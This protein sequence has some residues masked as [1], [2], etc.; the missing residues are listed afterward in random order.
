MKVVITGGCGFIGTN[1]AW[2]LSDKGYTVK[3]IDNFLVGKPTGLPPVTLCPRDINDIDDCMDFTRNADVVVHLAAISGVEASKMQP[4]LCFKT[5]VIGT[6]N[7]LE[8]SAENGVMK[9]IIA[10]SGAADD[11][12]SSPYAMSKWTAEYISQLICQESC[13]LR[14]AN[15]YGPKS[16]HKQSVINASLWRIKNGRHPIM[17]GNGNHSRDFIYIND[18]CRAIEM[19]ML[20][21]GEGTY[22]IATGENHTIKELMGMIG[23]VTG[24]GVKPEKLPERKEVEIVKVN[25]ERAYQELGFRAEIGLEEGLK[26]T[27]EAICQQ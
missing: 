25:T 26:M 23:K 5:N 18:V 19:A 20:S 8:A 16:E 10:S 7:V 11:R 21:E 15:V 14:F 24:N 2:Y 27:W 12:F 17:Y 1:L 3:V 6:A 4:E 22:N 13:V 9:V